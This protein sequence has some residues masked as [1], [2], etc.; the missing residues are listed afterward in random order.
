MLCLSDDDHIR[1]LR[2]A[3]NRDNNLFEVQRKEDIM[4]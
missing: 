4:E 2:L 1:E 3:D